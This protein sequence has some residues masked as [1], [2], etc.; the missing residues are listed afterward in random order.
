MPGN[1]NSLFVYFFYGLAFFSMG[2]LVA[3]EGGQATDVRLRSALRPLAVFGIIHAVHEWL[4]MYRIVSVQYGVELPFI[5]SAATEAILAFSFVSLAAFGS[6]LLAKTE[7]SREIILI[8]PVALEAIW[9]F[10]LYNL[11]GRYTGDD[12]WAASHAWVRYSLAIPA[13]MLAVA[14][15]IGQQRIFRRE[16]MRSFGRDSMWAAVAFAWYGLVGQFFVGASPLPPSNVINEQ[17]GYIWLP[18]VIP[19]VTAGVAAFFI[20]RFLRAFQFETGRRI[21]ALQEARLEEARQREALHGELYGRVVSA[22]EA[23]RQRIARDLHDETGQ[24]LTAIGMGLRGLSSAVKGGDPDRAVSTLRNLEGLSD[25]AL[26]ELQRL[27][28]DLRP[29]HLDDLGIGAALRWHAG[30]VAQLSGLR[31]VVDVLGEEGPV[32]PAVKTT[33]FRIVQEALNNIVKHAKAESANILLAFEDKV[34]RVRVRDDGCGFDL[35]AKKGSHGGRPSLGLAGMQ[36]RAALFGG[37]FFISSQ[38]GQGTLLEVIL[39]YTQP[40]EVDASHDNTPAAGG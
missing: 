25:S 19:A 39:P 21:A 23:E 22:Q 30:Q 20:I 16:G 26:T 37:E 33:I 38:P 5:V 32:S 8:I 6:Y 7:S 36:E 28:G 13:S 10:G 40:E 2:L 3:I 17:L 4:E 9:V 24:S 14:G 11:G 15:L 1:L 27:I 35:S 29:S 12:L 34:I 18:G 31:I